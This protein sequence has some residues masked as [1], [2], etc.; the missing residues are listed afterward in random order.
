MV[1]DTRQE[2][3][4]NKVLH[5]RS[6]H[7]Y[8]SL[9]YISFVDTRFS[10]DTHSLHSCSRSGSLLVYSFRKCHYLRKILVWKMFVIGFAFALIAVSYVSAEIR[11]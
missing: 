5:E 11:K 9:I 2:K 6:I 7:V 10:L 4:S 8:V 1:V 3:T